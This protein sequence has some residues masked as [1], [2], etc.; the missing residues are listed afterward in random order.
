MAKSHLIFLLL[1][2]AWT[3]VTGCSPSSNTADTTIESASTQAAEVP[4]VE[5]LDVASKPTFFENVTH[6]TGIDFQFQS[7]R[8]AGEFAI[9]ESLGGG[10]GVFD[11]DADGLMDIMFAG[12]G[13]L[14]EKLVSSLPCKI[15]RNRG[16]FRFEDVTS[17]TELA[18]DR[19]YNHGIFPADYDSDG[20]IDL[21]VSGYGGVQLFRNQGD[22]R[23]QLSQV[24]QSH[25]DTPWS[26]SLAWADFNRDGVLDLYVAHY[27]DW[28]FD[29][30]PS[31]NG[32]GTPREVCAPKDFKGVDDC[33]FLGDSEGGFVARSKESGL[34]P[35][36]KGLGVVASDFDLDGDVD[37]Y[38][39]NDTVDNFFY[40]NDGSGHFTENAVL[41]GVA[42]DEF[43]VSTGSMGIA[44]GEFTGDL[45]PDIWVTNFERELFALYRNEGNGLYTHISRTAG[46]AASGGLY[47]GFGTVPIDI[48]QDGDDDLV[49]ANGHVSYKAKNTAFKQ[50]PL[51]LRNDGQGRFVRQLSEGYFSELHSGRGVVS[52]DL[53]NDGCAD[54]IFSHLEEP[55]TILKGNKQ[56]R[57]GQSGQ[58]RCI[59]RLI[60]TVSNRDAIGASV[61]IETRHGKRLL[62]IHG[63]GSY[64]STSDL[65]FFISP[66]TEPSKATVRWPSGASEVFWLDLAFDQSD[67]ATI[68]W[69]EGQSNAVQ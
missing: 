68:V 42:G 37:L 19:F 2:F 62:G 29:N 5:S 46:L 6:K 65:R 60:G 39:A 61:E 55:P 45:L 36:G 12:G 22:G 43:G 35:S 57:H 15:F 52:A 34:L 64:L 38:V 3:I 53:N 32:D 26:S 40:I 4:A 51:L 1:L 28:S 9:L 13:D 10:V 49:V 44:V 14:R 47:V 59:L 18:A 54:L 30:H 23:F 8:G 66:P 20:F 41:A 67:V 33:L 48:D 56:S 11:F 24:L 7:G 27:V 21:A 58:K 63:G 50:V 17:Q 69:I 25:P 16:D 31:C